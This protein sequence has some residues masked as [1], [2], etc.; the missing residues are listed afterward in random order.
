[1][2]GGDGVGVDRPGGIVVTGGDHCHIRTITWPTARWT[3][4]NLPVC[5][6]SAVSSLVRGIY[7]RGNHSLTDTKGFGV[8]AP[9][10]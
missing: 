6:P 2:S 5:Q 9:S 4:V 10:I 3:R 1:M 8:C 7:V